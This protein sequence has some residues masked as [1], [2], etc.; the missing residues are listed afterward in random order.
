MNST[1]DRAK[2]LFTLT[3]SAAAIAGTAAIG[4]GAAIASANPLLPPDPCRSGSCRPELNP[5][6][7]PPGFRD[8]IPIQGHGGPGVPPR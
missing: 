8:H 3:V 1:F 7:L 2:K 4:F 6:P 5:Q